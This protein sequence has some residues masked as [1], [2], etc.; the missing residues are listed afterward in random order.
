MLVILSVAKDLVRLDRAEILRYA[1]DDRV[2]NDS[3]E[4]VKI[5]VF[6]YVKFEK[7]PGETSGIHSP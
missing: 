6:P 3:H 1:Q 2:Q 5:S 4:I 7:I